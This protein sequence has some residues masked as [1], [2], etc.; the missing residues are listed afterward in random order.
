MSTQPEQGKSDEFVSSQKK[1]NPI[2]FSALRLFK[3]K[4]PKKPKK[5][6]NDTAIVLPEN[7]KYDLS[8]E[9]KVIGYTDY[10]NTAGVKGGCKW[11]HISDIESSVPKNSMYAVGAGLHRSQSIGVTS[12]GTPYV[13]IT[14]GVG[15]AF[16]SLVNIALVSDTGELT[17]A[18]KNIIALLSQDKHLS[19]NSPL[20]KAVE[21][22]KTT[23]PEETFSR[24]ELFDLI[25]KW[26]RDIDTNDAKTLDIINTAKKLKPGQVI[27]ISKGVAS[28]S[29]Y[30]F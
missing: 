9:S 20:S 1:E 5:I 27:D 22:L 8:L 12:N 18:Q 4:T 3:K 2:G 19:E 21:S 24:S 28:I 15:S 26:A 10:I 17:P 6:E 13:R 7:G 16:Q 23:K 29:N 30:G 14:A 11:H 25:A